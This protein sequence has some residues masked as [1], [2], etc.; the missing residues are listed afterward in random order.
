M[1][2]VYDKLIRARPP[3]LQRCTPQFDVGSGDLARKPTPTHIQTTLGQ[4]RG[5]ETHS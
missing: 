5:L 4:V 2:E 1:R 3:R